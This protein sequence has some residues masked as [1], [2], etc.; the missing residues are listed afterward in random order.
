[1]AGPSWEGFVIENLIACDDL[2]IEERIVVYA[3]SETYPAKGGVMVQ[4]V[5]NSIE[6]VR[7]VLS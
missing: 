1:M 4:S 7:S 6:R 5:G 2:G 3:G